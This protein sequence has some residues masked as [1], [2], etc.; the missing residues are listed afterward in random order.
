[1]VIA[2]LVLGE[3]EELATWWEIGLAAAQV[4]LACVSTGILSKLKGGYTFVGQMGRIRIEL[5][6]AN[7]DVGAG[8]GDGAVDSD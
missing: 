8:G 5:V 6:Y 1:M 2:D 3:T 4:N 7:V